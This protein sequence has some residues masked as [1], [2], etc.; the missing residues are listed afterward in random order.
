MLAADA[1]K[2]Q[3]QDTNNYQDCLTRVASQYAGDQVNDACFIY[4]NQFLNGANPAPDNTRGVT[5]LIDETHNNFHTKE[6]RYKP[7]SLLLENDGYTVNS[8]APEMDF[9]ATLTA[10][11]HAVLLIANP[12]NA[13]NNIPD[14]KGKVTWSDP[15]RS[16]FTND[17]ID[18]LVNWVKAGGSLMLIADHYPFPGAVNTLA[19]RFGFFMDDGYNFDP[20]YNNVFLNALLNTDLAKSIMRQEVMTKDPSPQGGTITKNGVTK[21]RTVKDDLVDQVRSVMVMLGARVNS[22]LFWSAATDQKPE[23]TSPTPDKGFSAGDGELWDHPIVRGLNADE[24]IPFVTSFTGSSFTYQPVPG[25][26]PIT[27]LM[28]LGKDTYTLMTHSQDAYFGTDNDQ[29]DTNLVTEA[30]TN[31]KVPD[32]S[33]VRKDTTN[34]LQGAA[35]T[36]GD[37]KLAVFGEAG[38]FTA[39]IASD[40]K[41][42]MGFNN[43]MAK[44]NQQFVLN[45]VHWLDGTLTDAS[46][47]VNVPT[48]TGLTQMPTLL[49]DVTKVAAE[50]Q[51]TIDDRKA[52]DNGIINGQESY[53]QQYKDS[54]SRGCGGCTTIVGDNSTDPT[55]PLLVLIAMGYLFIPGERKSNREMARS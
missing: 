32:Y 18:G 50:A 9:N 34:S 33:V 16:A 51:A 29:S 11:P 53:A 21:D 44:Y 5:V 25:N 22:L 35:L 6:G 24:S 38:M 48:N 37:G 49:E 26:G 2:L 12:L 4:F 45:T 28:A 39:Q 19:Q 15:I 43:P 40:G 31:Q 41:S 17:E 42:Q 13:S 8:I 14:S 46:Q 10:N 54:Y 23:G 36:V 1:V 20:N 30:L 55:L 3:P 47:S 52:R 7:F 27:K